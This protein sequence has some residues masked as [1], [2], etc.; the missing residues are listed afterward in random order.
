MSESLILRRQPSPHAE[1]SQWGGA[2]PN[3]L[4]TYM[5]SFDS[6]YPELGWN[7]TRALV[8][9]RGFR[10]LAQGL[11]TKEAAVGAIAKDAG[12]STMFEKAS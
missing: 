7:V 3:G 1:L 2:H 10:I 12:V 11:K 5:V 6:K 9:T 8:G 4:T